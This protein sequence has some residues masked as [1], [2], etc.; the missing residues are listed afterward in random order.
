VW[1]PAAM[2][3]GRSNRPPA[4]PWRPHLKPYK[5][6][7]RPS[8]PQ[9]AS[10]TVSFRP[11]RYSSPDRGSGDTRGAPLGLLPR[12]PLPVSA[13]ETM[14]K[15]AKAEAPAVEPA[16]AKNEASA[17]PAEPF[18]GICGKDI[19]C[20]D[21]YLAGEQLGWR[22]RPPVGRRA[23]TPPLT[24]LTVTDNPPPCAPSHPYYC[25]LPFPLSQCTAT[26]AAQ[27]TC[28]GTAP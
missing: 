11:G 22:G 24:S 10:L 19:D 21:E 6:P 3:T 8:G 1:A 15:R 18:C 23:F 27:A 14:G 20:A 9:F 7:G 12:S 5:P 25:S 2:G 4:P 26:S 17:D 16:A 13:P 28:T